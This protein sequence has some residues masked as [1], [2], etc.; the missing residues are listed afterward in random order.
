MPIRKWSVFHALP[1]LLFA[2]SLA[3][4][5]AA[6]DQGSFRVLVEGRAAGSEEF[7]I[8]QSG[9]GTSSEVTAVGRIEVT[10]PTG[11]LELTPRLRARG[12]EASPVA[13]QVDIGGD[14]PR[15]IIGTV[16]SGRVSTRI[17]SSIG[18]QLREYVASAGAVVLDEGVA[19]HYYFLAQRQ[20]N[21]TV[22]VI[23]PRENRQVVA[24]VSDRGEERVEIEGTPLNLF[25]LVVQVPGASERHVWVDAL[26]RVIRVR[27][28]ERGYEAVRTAIPR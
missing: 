12:V 13:Y 17:I 22:P 21:G 6:V 25:H 1:V 18:E 15:K 28:P 24:T 19:H 14:S 8:R 27:I 10:L 9:S 3:A 4:Q 7:S 23:I 20:R 16:G 2:S 11:T 5:D 26:N